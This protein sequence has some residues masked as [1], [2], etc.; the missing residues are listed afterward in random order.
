MCFSGQVGGQ[1]GPHS[2][3]ELE[4]KSGACR[5]MEA[6]GTETGQEKTLTTSMAAVPSQ[7]GGRE[8]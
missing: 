6:G 7:M 8:L 5:E 1:P 2:Q 3:E 4:Q